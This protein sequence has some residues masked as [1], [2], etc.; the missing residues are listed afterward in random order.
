M[1]QALGKG[2]DALIKQTKETTAKIPGNAVQKISVTRIHPNR[3]QPRRVFDEDSLRELGQSIKQHGLAQPILVA[4]DART[5]EYELIAGERRLRA[6]QLAGLTEIDAIVRPMPEQ[7]QMLALALIENIQR[8]DLN[9]IDTAVAYGKLIAEHN[10]AQKELARYCGKSPSAISNTL[11]LLELDNEI[12][13]A[14]QNNVI[15]EGHARAILTVPD[16]DARIR[17]YHAIMENKA[18]V[19]QTED[20]ARAIAGGGSKKTA[21]KQAADKSADVKAFEDALA[22]KLGTKVELRPGSKGQAG[23]L[24]IHYHTFEELDRLAEKLGQRN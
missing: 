15:T 3:H 16:K 17:L 23:Q 2:L 1:R 11:R 13:K 4:P 10:V 14:L 19:R 6:S 20:L 22:Q 24:I 7:E 9:P 8:E 12:Q 18:S 21:P 5:G